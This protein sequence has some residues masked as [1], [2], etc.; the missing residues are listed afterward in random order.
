ML[1]GATKEEYA[2]HFP[3]DPTSPIPRLVAKV[4]AGSI[5]GIKASELGRYLYSQQTKETGASLDGARHFRK[6]KVARVYG[7]QQHLNDSWY[8]DMLYMDDIPVGW[9]ARVDRT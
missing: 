1:T 2:C 4:R 5:R 8:G 9:E 6:I 3:D 7:V